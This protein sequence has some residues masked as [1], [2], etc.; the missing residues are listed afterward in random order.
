MIKTKKKER[1]NFT[2]KEMRLNGWSK[3]LSMKS[4]ARKGTKEEEKDLLQEREEKSGEK[5][6][7]DRFANGS[8]VTIHGSRSR[9]RF[10]VLNIWICCPYS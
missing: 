3:W 8:G 1:R 10:R 9:I 4:E 5:K 7:H 2:L 6:K